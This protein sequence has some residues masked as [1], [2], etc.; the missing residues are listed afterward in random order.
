VRCRRSLVRSFLLVLLALAAPCP[1]LSAQ[2][3]WSIIG[4]VQTSHGELPDRRILLALQ[5]RGNTIA[6]AYCDS[7]GKFFFPDLSANVYHVLVDDENY[8]R[9][10]EMAQINPMSTGP[11]F[12]RIVL[13]PREAPR[14][15]SPAPGSNPNM[16][17]SAEFTSQIARPAIKEFKKGVESDK[18][19]RPDDAIAHYT[20][21]VGLAPDFYAARNN[22]GTAY[23]GKS[24][25]AAA[26]EQFEQV[27]KTNPSDAAAYFN[28][29][30]LF[31]LT[32]KYVEAVGSLDQ[33]L[34][35]QPNSPLGHFLLGS[36]YARTGK[37]EEAEK[38]LQTSLQLD[39]KMLKAHLAL[40]NLFL[41]RDRPA[42]AV[43]QLK[44]FL[45][46]GPDDPFAPKAREVLKRLEAKTQGR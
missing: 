14:S 21:A 13:V 12:V 39:P 36:V 35:K 7:E 30:N 33:G 46:D 4:T 38:E 40:V 25:F 27:I 28:L 44:Q 41:Q 10:E 9:V 26:Q 34:S 20:K 32:Q 15:E 1:P 11:T 18:D 3:G 6:T 45:K 17:N 23:L 2:R 37:S 43:Y 42:D 31:F 29:G 19:G 16:V 5:F 8:Q 24:Q 22:L